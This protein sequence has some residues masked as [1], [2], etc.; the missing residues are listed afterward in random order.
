M[1]I[2][3]RT[4]FTNSQKRRICLG[5]FLMLMLLGIIAGTIMVGTSENIQWLNRLLFTNNMFKSLDRLSFLEQLFKDLVPL[6]GVLIL[7]FFAGMFAFGQA[8]AVL[9]LIYRG[10]AS[11]ISAAI[12]YLVLGAKGFL[13][14]ILTVFPFAVSSAFLVILGARESVKLSGNIAKYSFLQRGG[15]TPPDIRLY[16]LKFG[17]LFIFGLVFSAAD[18]LITYFLNPILFG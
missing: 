12:I 16:T 14:V 4:S 5:M 17:I 6:Y 10:A 13:A 3:D 2:T 8:F 1:K 9:T 15:S 7:Q 11:G 18:T